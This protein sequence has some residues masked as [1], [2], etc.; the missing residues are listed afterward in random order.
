MKYFASSSTGTTA[1]DL[2]REM[3][4]S[5]LYYNISVNINCVPKYYLEPNNIIYVSDSKS[6]IYGD[7]IIT[8]YTLPLGYNGNMSI[9]T[10]QAIVRV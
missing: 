3:L 5:N 2:I 4:Y 10:N 9:T 8:Q 6:N 7:C 1:F